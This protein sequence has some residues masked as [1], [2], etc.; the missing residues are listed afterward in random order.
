[1]FIEPSA[2]NYRASFRENEPKTLVFM[3]EN[4][5]FGL[6]FVKTWSINSGTGIDS[7]ETISPAYVAWRA[8]TK[9][10]VVSLSYRPAS[11]DFRSP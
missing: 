4:E 8:G 2:R 1:M 3:T 9:N 7:E 10:R 5:R 6:V 11:I